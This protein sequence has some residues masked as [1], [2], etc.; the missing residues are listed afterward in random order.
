MVWARRGLTVGQGSV[1]VGSGIVALDTTD[2]A[3]IGAIK[4]SVKA[5]YL[6]SGGAF[7]YWCT[8]GVG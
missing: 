8:G 2:E 5:L 6:G 1:A 7:L 3:Y 4:I